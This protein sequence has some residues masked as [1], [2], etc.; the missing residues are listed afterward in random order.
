MNRKSVIS[1]LLLGILVIQIFMLGTYPLNNNDE[2]SFVE[3]INDLNTSA[4]EIIREQWLDNTDFST[5]DEWF[6]L[7]GEQGDNSTIDANI[8][9]GQANYVVV[10][11]DSS[12]S[13]TAGEV[14]SSTW[15]GWDIYNNSDFLLPDV[16]E[17]NATGC[18]VHHFLN[19]SEGAT[20]EGQVH[21]FPSAHFRKNVSLEDDMSD[22]E[23][24]SASL[25]TMF[26]GTVDFDVDTPLDKYN[27]EVSQFDI[28]DSATFYVEISDLERSYAFR[29][30][31]NKTKYLGQWNASAAYPSILN[32]TNSLLDTISEEDLITAL[33]LALQKDLTHSHFT[34]TLGIDIY[35]EDNRGSPGDTDKWK[36]LIFNSFNLT[37]S[38]ERKIEQ[39]TSISWNQI[40]NQLTGVDVQLINATFNFDYKIDELWPTSLSPFSEIAIII[41][42]NK[43]S[44]TIRLDTANNTFQEAK[45]G[46]FDVTSLISKDVDITVSIQLLIANTFGLGKNITFSIDDVELNITY[47]QTFPDTE[48]DLQIFINGDNKTADPYV[49]VPI[50]SIVNVTIRYLDDIGLYIDGG[51]VQ[52]TGVG[53]LENLIE[54]PTYQQYSYLVNSTEKLSQGTNLLTITTQKTN[55]QPTNLD[56]SIVVRKIETDVQSTTGKDII[57]IN[58]GGNINLQVYLNNTDFN[59]PIT[60]AL[61]LYNWDFGQ[62]ILRDNDNNGIYVVD[63][64]NIPAGSYI[65]TI[66]VFGSEDYAF[67][68][69]QVTINAIQGDAPDWTLLIIILSA[70]ML[71][72]IGFFTLYQTHFKYPPM[73]RKIRKIRKKINKDKK[74]K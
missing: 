37:F 64:N 4:S 58:P 3:P 26:N 68:E 70:G 54:N 18:Y 57:N 27:T 51:L 60:G 14:N 74:I 17:I 10:G 25:K 53:I 15:Y 41:N 50:G 8:S 23:I 39:F 38:Y 7:K 22:Y 48:P 1:T 21:N 19:E 33:N 36:A 43:H 32:I 67:Q 29:V 30:A 47:S 65:V 13:L 5:Q 31:E 66:S 55:F 11:E 72:I 40:G 35:C 9:S 63:L 34:I 71:G 20:N 2:N 44:E 56:F 6:Y 45:Q 24:T 73:V 12:F 46:G 62:G 42:D 59:L 52:L 61:I 49:E 69:Y 28:G 16:T